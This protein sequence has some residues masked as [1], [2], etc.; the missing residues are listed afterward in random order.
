MHSRQFTLRSRPSEW[1]T[2]ENF[3]L[4]PVEVT[5]P[6]DGELLIR[7]T[8]LSVDPYMRSL[9]LGKGG[10]ASYE[11][12]GPMSGGAVGVV[13]ESGIDEYQPGDNV[14]HLGGWREIA[15]VDG[16]TVR[17]IDVDLAPPAAYLGA[18]GLTGLSAYVGMV[19]IGR[20]TS[21]DHVLVSA[22]A[23]AVGSIAGQ[24]ARRRGASRVVGIAGSPEKIRYLTETLGFEYAFNYRDGDLVDQV[25]AAMPGGID[26]FFDNVGGPQLEAGL[27]SM[28]LHGRVVSC[29]VIN[30]TSIWD[31][32]PGPRNLG[33]VIPKRLTISGFVATDHEDQREKFVAEVAAGL[34]DG[35]IA[36]TE[37]VVHG[38]DAMAEAFVGLLKGTNTGKMIIELD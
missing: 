24:L 30:Q 12:G 29:G 3:E 1:P 36:A 14:V 15:R 2:I 22:A 38:L 37:T 35:S 8:H 26:M 31:L 33:L 34:S 32:A 19:T 10:D 17:K 6:G 11:I 27:A 25:R 9:M 5:P 23:G 13:L 20:V 16:S 21:G 18:L 4:L 7:N 28:N